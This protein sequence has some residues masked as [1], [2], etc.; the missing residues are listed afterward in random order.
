MMHRN[1]KPAVTLQLP[2]YKTIQALHNCTTFEEVKEITKQHWPDLLKETF[3]NKNLSTAAKTF[4]LTV[5]FSDDYMQLRP[6]VDPNDPRVRFFKCMKRLPAELQMKTSNFKEGENSSIV[7]AS[8][9]NAELPQ[10]LVEIPQDE[11]APNPDTNNPAPS[12]T[13]KASTTPNDA[14]EVLLIPSESLPKPN[15]CPSGGVVSAI[16]ACTVLMT[17]VAY[18]MVSSW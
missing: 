17:T 10:L 2:Q 1:E 7:L 13:E 16:L 5:L 9:V 15:P 6:D 18:Q 4:S 14:Q 3:W 12:N 11:T 8:L